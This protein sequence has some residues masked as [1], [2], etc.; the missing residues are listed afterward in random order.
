M[1]D[2]WDVLIIAKS[3]ARYS[4]NLRVNPDKKFVYRFCFIAFTL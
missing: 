1:G 3:Y 2:C 4:T